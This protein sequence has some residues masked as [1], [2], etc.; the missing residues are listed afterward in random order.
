MP[1]LTVCLISNTDVS[2]KKCVVIDESID[3]DSLL[4][5]A[6]NKL[7]LPKAKQLFTGWGEEISRDE[8]FKRRS[9][10]SNE[11]WVSCGEAYRGP[12]R[13]LEEA[14]IKIVGDKSEIS[15]DAVHELGVVAKLPGVI[16]VWGMP[17]LHSGPTGCVIAT[18]KCLYPRFVGSD[19]GCG[20]AVFPA[21]KASVFCPLK[22][23]KHLANINILDSLLIEEFLLKSNIESSSDD[24]SL[25]TI[26]GSNHFAEFQSVDTVMDSELFRELSLEKDSLLL[27]VHS[28]SRGF[29]KSVFED[30]GNVCLKEADDIAKYLQKHDAAIRWGITNRRAIAA[31]LLSNKAVRPCLDICHNQIVQNETMPEVYIHRK[32][33]APADAGCVIIPGSRG[34]HSYIVKPKDQIDVKNI[35]W[36]L[37]HGAGRRLSRTKAK[38]KALKKC[39]GQIESL[40]T[41]VLDSVVSCGDAQVLCEEI[42]EAYKNIDD[43][44]SDLQPF[45]YVVAKLKPLLTIKDF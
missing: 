6:K 28:G 41:T 2:V 27:T 1:L 30:F 3:V 13:C 40:L 19:A 8:Q 5:I 10:P 31:R 21:G 36:S 16:G 23:K 26:G 14:P 45:I 42:P 22:F 38:A 44:I 34:T 4:V 43:V 20:M 35:G 39:G 15:T 29:G 17:D 12:T 11:V 37:A 24:K 33:A 18:R 7:K 25:G 9:R 32:G